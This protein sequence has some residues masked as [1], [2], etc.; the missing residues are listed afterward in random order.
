VLLLRFR[1]GIPRLTLGM[2]DFARRA[3]EHRPGGLCATQVYDL[4]SLRPHKATARPKKAVEG[5]RA[6]VS[7][8]FGAPT[9]RRPPGQTGITDAGYNVPRELCSRDR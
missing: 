7:Q 1:V 3:L 8:M 6:V 4:C 9:A 5:T 2:T